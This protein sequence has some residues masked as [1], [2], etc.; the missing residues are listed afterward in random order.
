V[1]GNLI[2]HPDGYGF[3]RPLPRPGQVNLPDVYVSGRDIGGAMH[4]DKVVIRVAG[5]L[6]SQRVRGEII[7]VLERA[8][9]NIVGMYDEGRNF[10]FV[11]PIDHRIS[12]HIYVNFADSFGAEPGHVVAAEITEYPSHHRNPE[13]K[14]VEVLGQ[15]GDRGLDTELLIRKHGLAAEFPPNVIK[16]AEKLPRAIPKT[17][18]RSRVDLRKLPMVTID[19]VDA[20]DFDDAVSIEINDRGNYVLGVHIADVSYYVEQGGIIDDEAYDRATSI[21]LEDRVLPMLPERLS[22]NLCSLRE[23]EDRL[24]I[25]AKMEIDQKGNVV[26]HEIFDSVIRSRHRMR[27][28]RRKIRLCRGEPSNHE[29]ARPDAPGQEDGPGEPGLRFPGGPRHLRPRGRGH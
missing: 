6:T 26:A 1:V 20:K 29:Q 25:S 24:A 27:G 18:H 5:H 3:V 19:P 10:A 7:R 16:A 17:E 13:G 14:I 8:H 12:Q 23:N 28:A 15:R 2:G 22:N 9:R 4:G 11:V 21:Y